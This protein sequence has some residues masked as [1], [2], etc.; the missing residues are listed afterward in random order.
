[1]GILR[2][3]YIHSTASVDLQDNRLTAVS[4]K[5][6][7]SALAFC[8]LGL[9]RF[10]CPLPPQAASACGAKC[11]DAG[12]FSGFS[13]DLCDRQC[14]ESVFLRGGQ[15]E[16]I[17]EADCFVCPELCGGGACPAGSFA[18]LESANGTS[19]PCVPCPQGQF[20]DQGGRMSCKSCFEHTEELARKN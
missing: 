6:A 14:S 2:G 4:D 19:V 5:L 3:R 18:E 10:R 7:L 1:M 13:S 20:Q 8:N 12:T 17:Q 15:V 9:N 16:M 11:C